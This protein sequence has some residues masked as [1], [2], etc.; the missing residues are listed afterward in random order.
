MILRSPSHQAQT[1]WTSQVKYEG[2]T[3]DTTIWEHAWGF[4]LS[5]SA[6]FEA[7]IPFI[8][9]GKVTTTATASYDGKYG[10]DHS[11]SETQSTEDSKTVE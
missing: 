9:G 1:K 6:E 2:T 10:T 7:K 11:V 8:G 4:E 3:T 5:A